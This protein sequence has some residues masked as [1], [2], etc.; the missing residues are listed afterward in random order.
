MPK[1]VDLRGK[2]FGRLTVVS[3]HGVN[4]HKQ[5]L[6][7]C[8]CSCGNTAV[9]RGGALVTGTTKS[10]G[11]LKLERVRNMHKTHGYAPTANKSLLYKRWCHIKERCYN[12][13][14]K[15]YADYGGRGIVMCDEWKNNYP[16]FKEWAEANGYKPEL[17]LDRIDVNGPYSPENCRFVTMKEQGANKRNNVYIHVGTSTFILSD[18]ARIFGF[19]QPLISIWLRKYGEEATVKRALARHAREHPDA[20]IP[21]E[22]TGIVATI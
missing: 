1:V 13:N 3:K 16:A 7:D 5:V 2:T 21:K 12:K 6:W 18:F 9:I 15:C 10:C 8:V 22:R 11:C 17:T 20:P 14:S 4:K 19:G